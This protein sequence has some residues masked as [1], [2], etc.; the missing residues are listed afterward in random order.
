MCQNVVG[1][2]DIVIARFSDIWKAVAVFSVW[3][4]LSLHT[5][6]PL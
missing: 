2:R 5:L 3:V 6:K 1:T 4:L